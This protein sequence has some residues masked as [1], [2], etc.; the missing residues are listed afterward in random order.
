MI[1]MIKHGVTML[2]SL[3]EY[4]NRWDSQLQWVLFGYWCGMQAHTK[5]SPFM[6]LSRR[7]PKLKVDNYLVY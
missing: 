2:S 7:M 4:I 1:K 5:F 6:I 3:L